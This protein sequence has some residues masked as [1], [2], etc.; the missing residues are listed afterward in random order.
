MN[1]AQM[2]QEVSQRTGLPRKTVSEVFDGIMNVTVAHLRSDGSSLLPG[3]GKLEVAQREARLGRN[4]RTGESVTIAASKT[5]K[6][7]PASS[8]K[9]DVQ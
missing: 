1:K 5:V 9:A 8:L 6:F 7:K 4:P 2:V 3:L